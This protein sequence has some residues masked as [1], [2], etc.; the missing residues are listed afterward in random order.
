[1]PEF[2]ME[3]DVDENGK[4]INARRKEEIIRCGDCNEADWY[5]TVNGNDYYYCKK[6]GSTGHTAKAFCVYGGN[7]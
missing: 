4:L 2:I 6:H 5:T 1:M 3:F 7:K